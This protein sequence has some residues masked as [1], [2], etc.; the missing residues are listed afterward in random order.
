LAGIHRPWLRLPN[1]YSRR[2]DW[3]FRLVQIRFERSL[4]SATTLFEPL[5][6]P[7]CHPERSRG[8]CSS[9]DLSWKL[10]IRWSKRICISPA[11]GLVTKGFLAAACSPTQ[12]KRRLEWATQ[13][14]G[15]Y[16]TRLS[17]L[18]QPACRFRCWRCKFS[19]TIVFRVSRRCPRNCRSL[20]FARDDKQE[21]AAV[22][23]GWLPNRGIF[24]I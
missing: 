1:R 12:A 15:A 7:V 9:A 4:G 24:Q 2:D 19:L 14:M 5:P 22:Q 8:I 6:F 20:G 16:M 17:F 13:S 18:F 11:T 21:R 23:R 3:N 10:G